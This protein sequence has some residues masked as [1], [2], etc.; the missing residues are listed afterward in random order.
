MYRLVF[1]DL[2]GTLAPFGGEVRPAVREAMQAVVDSDKW[3]TLSTSRGYQ[4]VKPFLDS[5]VVNAPMVCCTGALIVEAS[6]RKVH[7]VKPLPLDMA[8]ALARLSEQEG[9]AMWFYLADMETMLEKRVGDAGFVLRRDGATIREAP[10][11]V[12]ELQEPPHKVLVDTPSPEYMPAVAA[13]VQECVGDRARVVLSRPYRAEVVL[14]GISKAWAMAWV[15]KDVG[16]KQEET[17]GIGDGDND[18]DMIQ[19]AGLGV[20]MGNAT[21]AVKAAADWIAPP[22]E[23]DGAA[24]ALRRF[25]LDL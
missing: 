1:C 3:I 8:H 2:D 10:D 11:P 25:V 12:A 5:V 24:E 6:T 20:A 16:V 21:P 9:I 4:M 7:F 23:E 17:I 13:R 15:A 14:P 19:W 18:L 22:V